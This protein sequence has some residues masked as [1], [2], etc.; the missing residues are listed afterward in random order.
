MT[1]ASEQLRLRP[2]CR[3]ECAAPLH[4][5]HVSAHTMPEITEIS[6]A[7]V[8]SQ[9]LTVISGAATSKIRRPAF[10]NTAHPSVATISNIPFRT[11]RL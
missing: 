9:W 7:D 6:T 5:A 1:M 3:A 2:E 11:S 4:G 10:R 8:T